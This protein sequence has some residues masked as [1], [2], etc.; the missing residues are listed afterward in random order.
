M[1]IC[2]RL[3]KRCSE[4]PD[5][6]LDKY[7]MMSFSTMRCTRCAILFEVSLAAALL[8]GINLYFSSNGSI[9][10]PVVPVWWPTTKD[11]I[12]VVAFGAL[13]YGLRRHISGGLS[14]TMAFVAVFSVICAALCLSIFGFS[15]GSISFSKNILL[16]FAGGTAIGALVAS[17]S[18]SS[19]TALRISRAILL[20]ILISFVCLALPVQS[21]DH[22]L[23]GTYGN[24]TSL[25]FA[26]F[27]LFA[28]SVATRSAL[29]SVPFGLLLGFVF[30]ATGSISV[31]IAAGAFLFIFSTLE[32][33][34]QR[35]IRFQVV[36]LLIIGLSGIVCG[37]A[38][39]QFG[40]PAIGY[41]RLTEI[42][43]AITHSDSI[44]VRLKAFAR[45]MNAGSYERYDVFL[46]GL[47]KN[48]GWLPLLAYAGLLASL[49]MMYRNSRQTK[50]Q[51]A[52]AAC[53]FCIFILNPLLQHQIEIFPTNF[54]FGAFL[55]CAIFSFNQDRVVKRPA[56]QPSRDQVQIIR[57]M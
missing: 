10:D 50:F 22:R 17:A 12:L 25:G 37:S 29:V 33:L 42:W 45:P 3:W 52:I 19:E 31:L 26:A 46:L 30:V 39:H 48:L 1:M 11:A 28:I 21:L 8:Y 40:G 47:Y 20:S 38:L 9:N 16:Y 32:Y 54:L 34:N 15:N 7:L 4:R 5:V 36:H 24:P 53:L 27:L 6:N 55:G 51:N 56:Q 18:S 35:P 41:V 57:M 13:L 49:V 2:R 44:T 14:P 43:D 23:Y